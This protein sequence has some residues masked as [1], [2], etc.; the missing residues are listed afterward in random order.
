MINLDPE[1]IT[2][3][4]HHNHVITITDPLVNNKETKSPLPLYNNNS[5]T[6]TDNVD[7]QGIQ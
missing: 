6:T 5:K 1:H 3:N 4:E 7:P 2:I